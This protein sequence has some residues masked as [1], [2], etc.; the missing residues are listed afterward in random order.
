MEKVHGG[1]DTF[2]V[3]ATRRGVQKHFLRRDQRFLSGQQYKS[4]NKHSE[5]WVPKKLENHVRGGE[6]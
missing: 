3:V 4:Q 2:Q 5:N 1:G 6:V